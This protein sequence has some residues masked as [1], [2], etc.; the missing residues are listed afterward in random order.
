MK[1]VFAAWFISLFIAFGFAA[2]YDNS[3]DALNV[4]GDGFMG[5]TVDDALPTNIDG[6]EGVTFS[7]RLSEMTQ[8]ITSVHETGNGLWQPQ[9]DQISTALNGYFDDFYEKR[10]IHY[11]DT[12]LHNIDRLRGKD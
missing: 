8:R 1:L 10:I 6:D 5:R 11:R 3:L 2:F 12:V 7:S 9:A 4:P